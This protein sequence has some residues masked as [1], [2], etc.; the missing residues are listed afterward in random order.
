MFQPNPSPTDE[1]GPRQRAGWGVRTEF[2]LV[3]SSQS[4]IHYL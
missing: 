2:G 1:R 4:R 3:I